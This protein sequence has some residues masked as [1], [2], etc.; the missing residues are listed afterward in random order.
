[1][2]HLQ[3]KAIPKI[4]Q[5]GGVGGPLPLFT[6]IS[7]HFRA[8]TS[9]QTQ[10]QLNEEASLKTMH[11]NIPEDWKSE[12]WSLNAECVICWKVDT[13]SALS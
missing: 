8:H 10:L 7:L 5:G 2:R 6:P 1:M 3:H 4:Q 9:H 12:L 13:L 11:W